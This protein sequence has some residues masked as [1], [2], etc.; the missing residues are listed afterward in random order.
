MAFQ[1]DVFLLMFFLILTLAWL[2]RHGWLPLQP[3]HFKTGAVRTTLH[4]LLKPRTPDDCPA[5][6]LASPASSSGGP[7]PL[8]VRPWSEVKSR[9]GS[10]K[11]INTEGFACPNP[12]CTYFGNTDAR[13]HAAFRRWQTWQGRTDPDL[14]VSGVPHHVHFQAQYPLVPTENPFLESRHGTIRA[15]CMT[16]SP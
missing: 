10:P 15:G 7:T 16:S 3:S 5:C 14:S 9:R 12:K 6:R 13:V 1:I 8:P 11:R 4:R 2:W